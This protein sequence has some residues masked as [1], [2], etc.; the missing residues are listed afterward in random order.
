MGPERSRY[1]SCERK[2]TTAVNFW[3]GRFLNEGIGAVGFTTATLLDLIGQSFLCA[4]VA[5]RLSEEATDVPVAV[6]LCAVLL[7]KL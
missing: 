1:F 6:G 3:G 7:V 2:A 5:V 4:W